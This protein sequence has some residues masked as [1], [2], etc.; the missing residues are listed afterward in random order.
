MEA[1]HGR[2]R[3]TFP[4]LA[5]WECIY[6]KRL[7]PDDKYWPHALVKTRGNAAMADSLD[8]EEMDSYFRVTTR[9]TNSHSAQVKQG[10]ATEAFKA[11]SMNGSVCTGGVASCVPYTTLR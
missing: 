8:I 5:S 4:L 6:F 2:A 11:I 9:R 10:L 1:I 3:V 7:N